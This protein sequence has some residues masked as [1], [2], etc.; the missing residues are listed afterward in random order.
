MS[1]VCVSVCWKGKNSKKSTKL[2]HF[3]AGNL[4][5]LLQ[6]CRAKKSK[7]TLVLGQQPNNSDS[8][9]SK[10]KIKPSLTYSHIRLKTSILSLSPSPGW[11]RRGPQNVISLSCS[12]GPAAFS[13]H[14]STS[15]EIDPSYRYRP[16]AKTNSPASSGKVIFILG[17][18]LFLFPRRKEEKKMEPS[19]SMLMGSSSSSST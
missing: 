3:E 2:K 9:A 6:D 19:V 10:K 13:C 12:N 8:Y 16:Y 14:S 7:Q 17:T 4:F 1:S 5:R 11:E 15:Y 18:I